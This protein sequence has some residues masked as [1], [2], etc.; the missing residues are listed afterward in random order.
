MGKV[1][2]KEEESFQERVWKE[3]RRAA[4]GTL[5]KDKASCSQTEGKLPAALHF[6]SHPK[7]NM[8]SCSLLPEAHHAG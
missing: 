2:W 3:P 5:G 6:M 8:I 1:S 4:E 7:P